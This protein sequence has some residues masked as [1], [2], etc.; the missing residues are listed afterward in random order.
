[1]ERYILSVP[2][3]NG[4]SFCCVLAAKR[5]HFYRFVEGIG[6]QDSDDWNTDGSAVVYL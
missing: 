1:M 3:Q 2:V 4:H 6:A 5:V